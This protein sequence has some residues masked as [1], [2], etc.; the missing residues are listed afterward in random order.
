MGKLFPFHL[1]HLICSAVDASVN[2]VAQ[3]KLLQSVINNHPFKRHISVIQMFYN[4][5][6]TT[7]RPRS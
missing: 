6:K 1:V 3:N 5:Q 2:L 4:K 7:F